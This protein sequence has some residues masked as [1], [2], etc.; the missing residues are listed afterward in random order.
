MKEGPEYQPGSSELPFDPKETIGIIVVIKVADLVEPAPGNVK[1]KCDQCQEPV[2][3]SP[4]A[5]IT[6]EQHELPLMD[7][8]CAIKFLKEDHAT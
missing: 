8:D 4:E 5:L 7:P 1:R 3:V 6:H 2:W